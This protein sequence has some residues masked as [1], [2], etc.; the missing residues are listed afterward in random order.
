MTNQD[1][2]INTIRIESEKRSDNNKNE[3]NKNKC[4][5]LKMKNHEEN[6]FYKKKRR[7]NNPQK[8]SQK[9]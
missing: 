3:D 8:M 6:D 5:Y 4:N 2:S 9:T 7:E 1:M